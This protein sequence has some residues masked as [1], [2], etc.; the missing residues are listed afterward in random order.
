MNEKS[1]HYNLNVQF[2]IISHLLAYNK[3]IPDGHLKTTL[4]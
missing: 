4:Y 2:E 1:L 3:N